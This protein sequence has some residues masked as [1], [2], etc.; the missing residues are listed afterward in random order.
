MILIFVVFSIL[1]YEMEHNIFNKNSCDKLLG[2]GSRMLSI[3]GFGAIVVY[4]ISR[5]D[6]PFIVLCCLAIVAINLLEC[7]AGKLSKAIDG[8]TTWQYSSPQKFLGRTWCTT[9]DGFISI[10]TSVFWSALAIIGV[11]LFIKN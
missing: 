9:C 3:Y 2:C 7:F 8:H 5:L 1:G 4:L 11:S 10:Q 6:L